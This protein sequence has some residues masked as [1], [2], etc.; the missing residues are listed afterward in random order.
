MSSKE[1]KIVLKSAREA[2][3][4]KEYK[5]AL[6]HCKAVLKQDKNNYNAWVFIGVAAAEL[7][8]LDQAKT[9]YKK[10][11]ELEP[12]Q[13]LAWQGLVNLYEKNN[14]S[15]CKHDL[16]AIY[17]KLLKLYE[18]TEKQK[19]YEVCQ[20]LVDLYHQEEKPLEAAKTWRRL[21]QMKQDDGVGKEELH[22][23]WK[24]I[25]EILSDNIENQD[26]GS[27][28]MLRTTFE[29]AL[30]SLDKIPS[31]EH[32]KLSIEYIK[33]LAKLPRE[34]DKLK[35]TCETLIT[36]YPNSF[37]PLE[38]L[39]MYFI[40]TDCISEE[41][42][43]C[44][45]RLNKMEP[46]NGPSLIGLGIKAMQEK[47]YEEAAKSI[48]EGLKEAHSA[49]AAWFYLGQAQL[50][51]H[52]Y[53]E[54][55]SACRHGLKLLASNIHDGNI[56]DRTRLLRLQA[57]AMVRSGDPANAQEAFG[58]LEQILDTS[59]PALLAIKGQAYLNKGLIKKALEIVEDLVVSHPEL[60]ETWVLQGLINNTL[61]HYLQAEQSFQKAVKIKGDC[62][63][64]YYYLGQTYWSMGEETRK[65][66]TKTVTHLL[67]AAKLDSYNG[68]IFCYL[69]HYYRDIALDKNRARGCYRKA[70]ELDSS[71]EDAG[72]AAVDLSLE[73]GDM[74]TALVI[75]RAVTDK[76]SAG[77]A[78][79]AWLRRGLYYMRINQCTQAI[80][81]L[82]AALRAD[83][84]DPNCW[85]CL[86]EAYLSRGGYTAALKAFTKASELNPNSVYNIYKI[87]AIKQILGKY[88]EAIAEYKQIIYN[89]QNYVPALKGLGECCLMM[90]RSALNDY[91][92]GRAVDIIEEAL[93]YSARAVLWRPDVSCLWKLIGDACTA[94]H[95]LSPAKVNIQVSVVL[96]GH[97]E[98]SDV[99]TLNKGGILILGGRCYGRALHLMST[100]ANLWCDLGINYY[101]QAQ[102]LSAS[103]KEN[104]VE[105]I[106]EK[107]LQCLKKC[108]M[109]DSRNHLYWNALGVVAS[110][111][112][113]A[114][115]ALAQHAFIKSVQVEQNNVVGWTNLGVTYLKNE[116]IELAHE[117]FKV[118]QSLEPSYVMCWIGQALIAETVGSYETMDL[119]RHT[120]ELGI[121]TEGAKGYA[122][123]VCATLQD[124]TN[125]NS[126]LYRY[127]I[128][129]MNAISA[130]QVVMSKFTERIQTDPAAFTMLGYLNEYLNLKKQAQE[131]YHRAA[132]L[133]QNAE[134]KEALNYAW[135]NLGRAFCATGQYQ[136]AIQAYMSTPLVEF[137]DITGLALSYFKKELLQESVKAYEKALTVASSE[138]EKAYILIALAMIEFKQNRVDSAKTLLFKCS[139]LKEP[140]IESLQALCALGLSKKDVTLTTAALKELLKHQNKTDSAYETCLLASGIYSL[141]GN[142]LAVQRQ[143]A[144]AVHSNPSDPALW[145]LLSRLVPQYAPHNANGGALVGNTAQ[146][147][148]F[149][150]PKKAL[151]FS[152]V[153]QIAAGKHVAEDENNN[154]LKTAQKVAH[155]YPDDPAVWTS[156]MAACH[157]ENT[158]S[159]IKERKPKQTALEELFLTVVMTKV[160][161]DK[162]LPAPYLQSLESW[163]LQQ[164]VTGLN[165]L[166][167]RAEAEAI[168]AKVL[169]KQP[170]QPMMFLLLRQV[171]CE[172]LLVSHE[173]LPETILEELKKAV[174]SNFTSITAWHWL[175]EVYK[176]H[177]LV[178]AAEM[179]YRQGLQVSSKQGQLNGKLASLLQLAL[180]AL[181]LSPVK[182]QKNRWP[183]LV[184]EATG[185]AQKISFCPLANLFQALL[186]FIVK[187]G[188]RETRRLL[189]RV[190][191][192]PGYPESIASV[193]RWYLLRHL[194]VKN[195]DELITVLLQDAKLKGDCRIEELYKKLQMESS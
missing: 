170:D 18:S 27:Q 145:T 21:I 47:K 1:V 32:Q 95:V 4:N 73:V 99:Q 3:R 91:L 124:K 26:N 163:S 165:E 141:Q 43:E 79:W 189:E 24:K 41:A 126:E 6:K 86:G 171:Q 63:E 104:E 16:L 66:K 166:G 135:R 185:E 76:A 44:F 192:Q 142:N 75:L 131:A 93:Q 150:H 178:G 146:I 97:S 56:H 148:N 70:F 122:H 87:A 22:Q 188:A 20:K 119:F 194:W 77:A 106:L 83:P 42:V 175:A 36:Q 111:K 31:D 169:K 176:S 12:D 151:L 50:R 112:D 137:D 94:L 33:F 164:A 107:S 129:Q 67:K 2:I 40:H 133:L 35:V 48:T 30:S 159:H 180:L 105:E 51:M 136:E 81:D 152:A 68:K 49:I 11:A 158:V 187:L 13:L 57:E 157:T 117:A 128:V 17:Q 183:S 138:K 118:A 190:V 46:N 160:E 98:R 64:Y 54:A 155:L 52:R 23:L 29:N 177:G 37:T 55:I 59:E 78:K 61:K 8:Q 193:G 134:D 147:L 153:N 113:V 195:D 9:A 100:S 72:A 121:H 179:C 85:E 172:Q 88:A 89:S 154:A 191:Y 58:V 92:D 140:S 96:T 132:V 123:W 115:Y 15:D 5:E 144:K 114:N 19:W 71:D 184:K 74:D 28:E 65:D 120:T 80:A 139:M 110:C 130:A 34:E 143:A 173:R 7:E 102:H 38:V 14:L 45:T 39:S 53:K 90:A 109:L 167:K 25:I 168:C 82:Q 162:T 10:A 62:G 116:S 84:K 161:A 186:Q 69:G 182:L 101:R 125:R 108:V 174:M 149:H 181:K 127:N 60:A 103:G 156:L